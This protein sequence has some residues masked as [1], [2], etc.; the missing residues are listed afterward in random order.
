MIGA[1]LPTGCP[2]LAQ[3]VGPFLLG[4]A[5]RQKNRS[6]VQKQHLQIRNPVVVDIYNRSRMCMRVGIKFLNQIGLAIEISVGLTAYQ[7]AALVILLDVRAPIEIGIDVDLDQLALA[8]VTTPQ[9]RAAI[10][11]LITGSHVD[12]R[13]HLDGSEGDAR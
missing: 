6:A 12:R 2:M 4:P 9:I 3:E 10:A 7:N 1:A 8:V 11:V 5:L 13:P